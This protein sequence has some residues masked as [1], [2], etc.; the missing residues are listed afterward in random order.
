MKFKN[1]KIDEFYEYMSDMSQ[2]AYSDPYLISNDVLCK[3]DTRGKVLE[4]YLTGTRLETG[5]LFILRKTVFYFLKNLVVFPLYL[6]IAIAHKFSGQ[7]FR[8]PDKGEFIVLDTYFLA[9]GILEQGKFKD[10]YFPGLVDELVGRNKNYAYV[11]RLLGT[12]SPFKWFRVFRILRKNADPILIEFQLLKFVDYLDVFRF[13]FLYPFSVRR[14]DKK[15]TKSYKDEVLSGGLWHALDSVPFFG[16]IRFLV[17][18]RL[19]LLKTEKIKCLSWYENQIFDK[20]F[21]RGLRVIPGKADIIGAQFFVKPHTLLN[22]F[23]D[24]SEILFNVVPDRIL[25]NGSGYLFKMKNTQV[26]VGPSLR[27]GYLFSAKVDPSEGE[28]I[29]ILLPFFDSVIRYILKVISKV[30]WPVPVEIKFHPGTEGSKYNQNRLKQ[31]FVTDKTLLEL[32]PKTRIVVGRS[33][34]QLEAAAL[35][36]PVIDIHDPDEFSHSYMPETGKGILWDQAIDAEG[37]SRLVSQFQ[38]DLQSDSSLLR[39]EGARLKSMYFSSPTKEFISE[40]FQLD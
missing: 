38:K 1:K 39:E 6:G 10:T 9:R 18:K 30:N 21:F 13:I 3:Q 40:A 35:G 17:G 22:L 19:S 36:I 23:V 2:K 27:Y 31:F 33:G 37:I 5:A 12:L 24:E 7:M 14:F 32:L 29:L 4:T 8:F 15:L 16:Y 26:D 28:I 34:G 25:V 11:P 20:N